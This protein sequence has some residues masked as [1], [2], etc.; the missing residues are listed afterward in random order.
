M[1]RHVGE[2]YERKQY[3]YTVVAKVPH[4]SIEGAFVYLISQREFGTE[5]YEYYTEI[6]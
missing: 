6:Y 5:E 3:E 1:E 2:T 4:A